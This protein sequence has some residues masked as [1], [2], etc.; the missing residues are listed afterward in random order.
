MPI[1][2]EIPGDPN[3]IHSTADWL[4]ST[5]A[6]KVSHTAD[7]IH[8]ARAT[9]AADW[10][11][12]AGDAFAARMGSG[13]TK[14]EGLEIAINEGAQAINEFAMELQRAQSEMETIRNTAMNAG[15][16]VDGSIIQ[17]ATEEALI[18][19]YNAAFHGA[20]A[21]RTMHK[22]AADTL[23]NMWG[24]IK[25]KWFFTAGDLINTAGAALAARY[26]SFLLEGSNFYASESAKFM[27]LAKS[28]P[29]GTPAAVIYRDFDDARAL[30]YKAEEA[31]KKAENFKAKAGSFSLKAGGALAAVGVV[32][33]IAN[34]KDVDQAI[35]SGAAGF[36][37]SVAA[38]ALIGTAIPVP[39]V[40]TAVGAVVGAG[41]GIFTSGAVDSL[42]QNGI[43]SLG[44]AISDGATAV[45]DAGK[46]VGGLAKGAWDAIF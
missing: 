2:T 39:V 3:S 24:D 29:P 13:A 6:S 12:E 5:L 25:N 4:R 20:E 40:G 31:A 14:A 11:G 9:A 10:H 41:V 1:D 30:A 45:A 8:A 33:D 27:D 15:L 21:A 7:E 46:A 36:G 43:G 26:A 16:T 44:S 42:Y 38:G 37:A 22:L 28:A 17:D 23:K 19:A 35:V 32:Y 34:G 18:D